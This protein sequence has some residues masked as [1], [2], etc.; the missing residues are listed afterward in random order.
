MPKHESSCIEDPSFSWSL[1]L[2][3]VSVVVLWLSSLLDALKAQA[4]SSLCLHSSQSHLHVSCARWVT[5]LTSPFTSSPI[6]SSLPSSC[7]SCCFTPSTSLMSWITSPRTSAEELGPLAEQNSFT[8]YDWGL[9]RVHPGVLK[10]ATVPWRLRLRWY[11]HR[12]DAP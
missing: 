12:S 10:R 5:F 8:G 7:S 6:S 1:F 9:C 3:S 4:V 11:Y 2:L